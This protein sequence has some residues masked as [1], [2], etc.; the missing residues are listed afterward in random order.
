MPDVA[1]LCD[2]EPTGAFEIDRLRQPGAISC[3]L[4]R[5]SGN[6]EA[7]IVSKADE[8]GCQPSGQG[9]PFELSIDVG[10]AQRQSDVKA[11]EL[12]E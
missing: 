7:A 6:P 10:M 4:L 9:P 2:I 8:I 12:G 1:K 11:I 3:S 5:P